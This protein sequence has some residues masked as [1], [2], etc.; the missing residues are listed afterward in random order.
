LAYRKIATTNDVGVLTSAKAREGNMVSATAVSDRHE[1]RVPWPVSWSGV[2][3]GSL[4]AVATM[5]LFGLAGLALGA[6]QLRD[7]QQQMTGMGDLGLGAL[8]FGVLG[9]FFSFVIGGW[10]AG[11]V[12]GFLLSEPAMLHGGIVWLVALPILIILAAVGAGG[13]F[14]GWLGGLAGTPAWT[15]QVGPTGADAAL[16]ARNAALGS[17]TALLIGLMG[18]VIGGWLASGEPMT[19]TH[20][21]TRE[22]SARAS[23]PSRAGSAG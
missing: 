13:F 3:L 16:A 11:K 8:V 20:Y 14:G 5:L 17:L 2:W 12:G 1:G 18:G 19:F 15:A 22:A 4:A 7:G 10:V 9:A 23:R 6:H 21:R